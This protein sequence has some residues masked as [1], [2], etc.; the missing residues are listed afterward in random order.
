MRRSTSTTYIEFMG[1]QRKFY[2]HYQP[3]NCFSYAMIY[4]WAIV[5]SIGT[6]TRL[7]SLIRGLRNQEWQRVLTDPEDNRSH[8]HHGRFRSAHAL[9]KRFIIIP[10][11]F[12]NRCSQPFGWCTI[13]NRVQSLTIFAFVM[14][15]VLLCTVNYRLTD[16]NLYWP[17]YREQ[18]LRYVSDRTG[19]ISLINFPL[20]WLFGMR[21]NLL[22]WLTGW[23]FGTYNNFHRWVARVSTVQ[24]IIHSIGYTIMVCESELYFWSRYSTSV[25]DQTR[26]WVEESNEVFYQTLL[27]EWRTSDHLHVCSLSV[28]CVRTPA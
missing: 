22:I 11:T 3:V 19:I 24:A 4:F 25:A 8:H 23:D 1:M 16:G 7:V 6:G 12:N 15:N 5:I 28:F 21:N 27:L 2:I 13:P 10:A 9:L 26:W 18:L 14:L 17:A 20:I